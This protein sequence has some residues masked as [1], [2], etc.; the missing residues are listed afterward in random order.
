M[1]GL[2]IHIPFCKKICNYCDFYRVVSSD[3]KKKYIKSVISESKL[4]EDYIGNLEINTVYIGGGTPSTLSIKELTLLVESLRNIYHWDN[5]VEFTLEANPDDITD[6]YLR[7][8]KDLGI[9]RISIGIQSW[10]DRV[11]KMMN[12]RHDS[13]RA[14]KAI[15][16]ILGADFKN[17]SIDLIYGIPGV[18]LEEWEETLKRTVALDIQHLSVYHLTIE[19][20]TLFG[21]MKKQ[22]LL[23]EIDE[24]DS[25]AQY[26]LL[27]ELTEGAGFI[28]Y[29]ISNFGKEGFFSRHNTSYWQQIPYIGLGPSAHSFNGFSRQWNESDVDK[30]IEEISNGKLPYEIEELD[31]KIRFNEYVMTSLRTMWGINLDIVEKKFGKE[32]LDYTKNLA[33]KYVEYGM[34]LEKNVNLSLTKQGIMISDNIISEFM[35]T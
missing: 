5:D 8:I 33:K 14:E 16:D 15:N 1:A 10:S 11:L 25:V 7:G 12:R 30:Y 13:L 9:N 2:Y 26:N 6:I 23:D 35:L 17:I 24:E 28:N 22:G 20:D 34:M 32:I 29:E 19:P 27:L 21:T 18:T 4:R 31:E 3:S